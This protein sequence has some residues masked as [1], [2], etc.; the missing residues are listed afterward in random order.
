MAEL[1]PCPFCG[2]EASLRRGWGSDP[3]VSYRVA[4]VKCSNCGIMTKHYT[5][6]GYYGEKWSD[7]QIAEVWN[8]RAEGDKP[9]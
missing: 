1:K 5:T 9:L 8:R 2:G 3:P 4:Y 6:D 7:E